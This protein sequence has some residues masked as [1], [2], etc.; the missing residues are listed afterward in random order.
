MEFEQLM[1]SYN[2]QKEKR[3][4]DKLFIIS[5]HGEGRMGSNNAESAHLTFAPRFEK[6]IATIKSLDHIER[7]TNLIPTIKPIPKWPKQKKSRS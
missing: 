1:I 4:I 5:I 7:I 3:G 6:E 2:A